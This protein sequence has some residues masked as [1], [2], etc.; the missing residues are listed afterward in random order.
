M[1]WYL[2]RVRAIQD[3]FKEKG[4]LLWVNLIPRAQN[5][6]ANMMSILTIKELEQLP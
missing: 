3:E 5:E 1:K 6:E 2:A 4:I